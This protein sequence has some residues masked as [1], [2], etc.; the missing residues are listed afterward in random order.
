[1]SHLRAGLRRVR[2]LGACLGVTAALMIV[3]VPLM[4]GWRGPAADRQ[5]ILEGYARGADRMAIKLVST[6]DYPA[7]NGDH[8]G[9][10]WVM[11]ASGGALY[12][13]S[14]PY[15]APVHWSVSVMPAG[16]SGVGESWEGCTGSWPAFFDRLPDHP[17]PPDWWSLPLLQPGAAIAALA[18]GAILVA[19]V[20]VLERRRRHPAAAAAPAA[21]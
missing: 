13:G 19:M 17:S 20:F 6:A 16:P 9:Y 12:M 11:A 10:V 21:G 4:A 14:F 1:M 7:P 5:A 18:G 8:V 3:A 2:T 15:C